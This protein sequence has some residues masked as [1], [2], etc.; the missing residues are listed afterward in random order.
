MEI[1]GLV[2]AA[3]HNGKR[4]IVKGFKADSGRFVVAPL[5]D[6]R[7]T[8]TESK[9]M[10]IKPA[11]LK[12]LQ[13][14]DGCNQEQAAAGDD[15]DSESEQLVFERTTTANLL[16]AQGKFDQ[17]AEMFKQNI[18]LCNRLYGP[19]HEHTINQLVSA[20]NM[21]IYPG[22]QGDRAHLSEARSLLELAVEQ[23][24]QLFGA[25]HARTLQTKASLAGAVRRTAERARARELLEEVVEGLTT[26]LGRSHQDTIGEISN[27]AGAMMEVGELGRAESLLREAVAGMTSHFGEENPKTLQVMFNL[28]VYLSKGGRY[29]EARPVAEAV[30]TGRTRAMGSENP[31]TQSALSLAETVRLRAWDPEQR[32]AGWQLGEA[33]LHAMDLVEQADSHARSNDMGNMLACARAACAADPS[34]AGGFFMAG[35]A[36]AAQFEKGEALLALEQALALAEPVEEKPR[37][38][39]LMEQVRTQTARRDPNS[40]RGQAE[41]LCDEADAC[42]KQHR[43][44]DMLAAAVRATAVDPTYFGGYAIR[45]RVLA[46]RGQTEEALEDFE[47]AHDLAAADGV[48]QR[49]EPDFGIAG[50]LPQLRAEIARGRGPG[51]MPSAQQHEGAAVASVRSAVRAQQALRPDLAVG[52]RVQIHGLRGAREHNGKFAVVQKFDAQAGRYVVQL[53]GGGKPMKIKPTNLSA[54]Q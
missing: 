24:T 47:T 14:A 2:G 54:C 16:G 35:S 6:P 3:H 48:F 43:V 30:A 18:A 28:C 36:L 1:T 21:H 50:F 13:S 4:C 49:G 20:A 42:G 44:D 34:F 53:V 41:Q 33:R 5:G 25:G 40:A 45:G 46:S 27:L 26:Q 29:E 31:M 52:E 32:P 15:V 38:L 17:A 39:A 9:N 22:L 7:L 8:K 51:G 37:V 10:A 12:L 11:N 19:L 23:N